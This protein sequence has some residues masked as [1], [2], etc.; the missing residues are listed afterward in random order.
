MYD[1][2]M[3]QYKAY[4]SLLRER[5][6]DPKEY[7]ENMDAKTAGRL[8]I[9][10]QLRNYIS[11]N[12]DPGFVVVSDKQTAFLKSCVNA[13]T[14]SCDIVKKHMRTLKA[15]ACTEGERCTD[16]LG[17]FRKCGTYALV[18]LHTDGSYGFVDLFD[19]VE[20]AFSGKGKLMGG[21][22]ALSGR[23]VPP[24]VCVDPAFRFADLPQGMIAV[25][26]DDGTKNGKVLGIVY[27]D[28]GFYL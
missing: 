14:A 15:G 12:D 10:R 26:T 5:G 3:S 21:V 27:P 28:T 6:I 7:E 9:C 8:R 20:Y 16:V 24:H 22:K 2:F 11:H 1:E 25:C 23:K 4:E 18:I 13:I 17:K 19:T